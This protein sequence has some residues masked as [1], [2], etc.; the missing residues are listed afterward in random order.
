[1]TEPRSESPAAASRYRKRATYVMAQQFLAP[2][3]KHPVPEGV[4]LWH[5]TGGAAP[6]DMSWG[7]VQTPSGAVHIHHGDWI[8]RQELPGLPSDV[9]PVKPEIFAKTYE[10]VPDE[11]AEEA[12]REDP[13]ARIHRERREATRPHLMRLAMAVMELYRCAAR[14]PNAFHDHVVGFREKEAAAREWTEAHLAVDDAAAPWGEKEQLA[15]RRLMERAAVGVEAIQLI[16]VVAAIDAPE[17]TIGALRALRDRAVVFLDAYETMRAGWDEE[18]EADQRALS[19][20]N[21]S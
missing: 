9:W 12:E 5:D 18:N 3:E 8:C 21:A 4:V 11:S 6:R 17:I 13:I 1:M 2:P 19:N 15:R 7:Y 16:E 20:A 10:P 14:E